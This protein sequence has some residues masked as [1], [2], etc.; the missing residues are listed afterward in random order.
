MTLTSFSHLYLRETNFYTS[1]I[2]GPL[3][4]GYSKL[5][6]QLIMQSQGPLSNFEIGGAPLVTQSVGGHKTIFLTNSL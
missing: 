4:G 2:A 6:L 1:E 5:F 3:I